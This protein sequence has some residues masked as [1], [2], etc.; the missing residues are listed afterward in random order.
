MTNPDVI[1]AAGVALDIAERVLVVSHVRPDGDAIASV[2]AMG[3]SLQAA[4]KIVTMVMS[5]GV[6]SHF[7]FLEGHDQI[8]TRHGGGFDLVVVLDCGDLNR[9]GQAVQGMTV[10]LNIDHHPTN[11]GFGEINI[12]ETESVATCEILARYIP[13]WGLPMPQEVVDALLTGILTDSQGFR[14]LNTTPRALKVAASL[15]ERG[16]DIHELYFKSLIRKNFE[17]LRYWGE[18][19][20]HLERKNGLAWAVLSLEGRKAAKYPGRDDADLVNLLARL[21]N[22]NV[23][24]LFVEQDSQ[25]V[26]ISWR[27][28]EGYNVAE[29]AQSFG[30]GGHVAAAGAT[31]EGGLEEVQQ[32]VIENTLRAIHQE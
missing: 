11:N 18:G 21:D 9:A 13:E 14:T 8:V 20:Q 31:I 19:L 3:L 7:R 10:G 15:M 17:A 29:I 27:A 32:R 25:K 28:K 24:I 23:V 30:G 22:T 26:K 16:A 2:L 5:D 1:E 4:G 6:P 12:I